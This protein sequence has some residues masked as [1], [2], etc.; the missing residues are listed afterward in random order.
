VTVPD[1]SGR[2]AEVLRLGLIEGMA[3]RAIARKLQMTRKTVRKVLGRH[4]AVS[5]PTAA[6]PRI[7]I[8]DPYLP[9]IRKLLSDSPEMLA[10]AVLERLRPLGYAGGVTVLRDRLR[11]LRPSGQE[12]EAFLVLNFKPGAAMQVDWGDFGFAI[13]GT[14]RRV[15]AFVAVLCYSRQLYI[16][17]TLSQAMGA[18]L[19]CMDRCLRYFGG[20]TAVDIFD[21]MKTVV[22]SHTPVATVFNPRFLEYAR[23]RGGFGVVACNVRRG[24]EKGVVE[25]GIGFVRRRFWPGRRFRD[26]LDLNTQAVA[27]REDFA[28][29]RV[30]EETGKV[31]ALVFEHE[32]KRLLRAVPN[33][34]FDTDDRDGLGVTKTC[35]VTFDRNRYSVPWWLVS[36]Q[37][38]VRADDESVRVFLER[39][40]IALHGRSWNIAQD[41][42][43]PS[44]VKGLLERKP[45]AASVLPPQ[46]EAL[47]ATGTAYCKVLA[48]GSRSI[49]REIVRLVLL[50]E[51][52]GATATRDAMSEVMQTGH[53]GAE[54]VEYVLRHK[55]GLQPNRAPLRLGNDELD[56]IW[57][58]E[59][60]L[61]VYDQLSA[62]SMTRDPG[63]PPK[64]PAGDAS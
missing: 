8:L 41:I 29:G 10:P 44:H 50:V 13:P 12:R 63:Q 39:K 47:G 37:V 54:Y 57:L 48:A 25:R 22:L 7:S 9:T 36:Q 26:L 31:P 4:Q 33:V 24:N 34:D 16:E 58:P 27:W 20:S 15:C 2:V 59:P 11:S 23:A 52:F 38:T 5:K 43:H 40:Q 28:N 14:P 30:H 1:R 46:L 18:F 61:S 53:V 62:T 49:H 3:L 19:R 56:Q 51:L 21:N 6:A 64:D 32:E 45:R 55:R 42:E 17:F 35:R 60:D